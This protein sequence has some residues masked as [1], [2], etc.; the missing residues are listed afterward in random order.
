MKRLFTLILAA[1]MMLALVACGN[2]APAESASDGDSET[3]NST[4]V[5]IEPSTPADDTEPE[6][7]TGLMEPIGMRNRMKTGL[8][9]IRLNNEEKD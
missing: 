8:R 7:L 3:A 9:V 4:N 2:S 5:K 6:V 1:I